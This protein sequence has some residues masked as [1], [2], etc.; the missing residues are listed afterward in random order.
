MEQIK[1]AHN[2]CKGRHDGTSKTDVS[3]KT[4]E[5][6]VEGHP[7]MSSRGH[8]QRQ[9]TDHE[10]NS[11]QMQFAKEDSVTGSASD[12]AKAIPDEA[13]K[14]NI[15]KHSK[16][17]PNMKQESDRDGENTKAKRKSKK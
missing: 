9:R 17:V 15:N 11:K 6:K 10:K 14:S 4:E 3:G 1:K 12:T 16:M 2:E 13:R 8:Q 5:A 7:K